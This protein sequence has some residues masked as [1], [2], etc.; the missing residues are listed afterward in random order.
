MK[1]K[2]EGSQ[3]KSSRRAIFILAVLLF[4]SVSAGVFLYFRQGQAAIQGRGTANHSPKSVTLEPFIVNLADLNYRRYLR[5][6]VVLEYTDRKVGDELAEKDHRVRD[7]VISL[8][9]AK[10]VADLKDEEAVRKELMGAVNG[11]LEQGK[12][13]GLYFKEFVVQ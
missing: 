9:R 11:V 3:Q 5:A 10:T 7:A 6:S 12:V 2:E 13:T 1:K 8:L 4:L